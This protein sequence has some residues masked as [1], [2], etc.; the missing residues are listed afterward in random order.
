VIKAGA[1]WVKGIATAARVVAQN[2]QE[3]AVLMEQQDP[4]NPGITACDREFLD[5]LEA[6]AGTN[7]R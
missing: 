3:A 6:C 7:R 5:E 4:G 1:P 2:E